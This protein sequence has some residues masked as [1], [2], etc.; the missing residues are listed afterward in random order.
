M[1]VSTGKKCL[2]QFVVAMARLETEM[3]PYQEVKTILKNVVLTLIE[4]KEEDYGL[5][6]MTLH[7]LATINY[8]EILDFNEKGNSS[9]LIQQIHEVESQKAHENLQ[10]KQF[11]E[12]IEM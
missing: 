11:N 4:S 7:N 12:E 3:V 10:N 1:E 9:S 8:I 6:K 5:L 2:A